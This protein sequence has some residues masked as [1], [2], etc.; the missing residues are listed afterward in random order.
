MPLY[1]ANVPQYDDVH[2]N[3][4]KNDQLTYVIHN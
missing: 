4:Q 2:Y 1:N 3:T